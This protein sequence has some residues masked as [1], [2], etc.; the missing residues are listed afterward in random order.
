L[1]VVFVST[2]SFG[3]EHSLRNVHGLSKTAYGR[4]GA[5]VSVVSPSNLCTNAVAGQSTST[6]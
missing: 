2:D 6:Q 5:S 4:G 3:E 1:K